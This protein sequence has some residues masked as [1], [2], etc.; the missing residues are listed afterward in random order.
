M[1]DREGIRRVLIEILENDTG[2]KPG[3]LDDARTLAGELG[4]DSVDVVSMMMQVE[5]RFRI[6]ADHLADDCP[7]GSSLT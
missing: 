3:D 4:L 6:R 7:R 5:R 2:E 1:L